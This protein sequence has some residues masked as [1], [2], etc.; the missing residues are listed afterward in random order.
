[1]SVDRW[2]RSVKHEDDAVKKLWYRI[3]GQ[4]WTGPVFFTKEVRTPPVMLTKTGYSEGNSSS[5]NSVFAMITEEAELRTSPISSWP[6]TW[7][8]SGKW[9]TLPEDEFD[10]RVLQLKR[11]HKEQAGTFMMSDDSVPLA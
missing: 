6:I 1:M 5:S 2:D 4:A 11:K 7:E 8:C 9:E 10:G 3:A